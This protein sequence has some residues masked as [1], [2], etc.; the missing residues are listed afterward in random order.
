MSLLKFIILM[1]LARSEPSTS[2]HIYRYI[3]YTHGV[4][5]DVEGIFVRLG[6]MG[7]CGMDECHFPGGTYV[8]GW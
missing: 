4:L 5:G 3:I 7:C 2:T 6:G 8:L 1:Q